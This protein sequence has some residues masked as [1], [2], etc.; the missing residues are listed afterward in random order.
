M[1]HPEAGWHLED[2]KAALRKRH[3]TMRALSVSL[4]YSTKAVSKALTDPRYS[5]TLEK[6]IALSLGLKPHVLWPDRWDAR[7]RPLPRPGG[8]IRITNNSRKTCQKE[9]AA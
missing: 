5:M 9:K 7:G 3:R 2:I 6:Q 1:T 8:S 4:G